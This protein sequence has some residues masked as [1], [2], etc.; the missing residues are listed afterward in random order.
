MACFVFFL[1]WFSD[2]LWYNPSQL[3]YMAKNEWPWAPDLP[4]PNSQ[5]LRFC[6]ST[7]PSLL[8]WG[9]NPMLIHDGQVFLPQLYDQLYLY[10]L[11]MFFFYFSYL[12]FVM[13]KTKFR[14]TYGNTTIDVSAK[15]FPKRS[16]KETNWMR[17][18]GW[19]G[20]RL[21]KNYLLPTVKTVHSQPPETPAAMTSQPQWETHLQT[22]TNI[23]TPLPF[24]ELPL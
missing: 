1:F 19:W 10:T 17:S 2:R 7:M 18:P 16:K 11:L 6:S 8:S 3:L 14:L 13:V 4:A 24:H 21:T 20:V 9:R 15:V 22:V 5:L 12:Y 23:R